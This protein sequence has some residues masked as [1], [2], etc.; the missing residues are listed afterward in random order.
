MSFEEKNVIKKCSSVCIIVLHEN[1]V[2][3]IVSIDCLT[4]RITSNA[5]KSFLAT[6]VR[7]VNMYE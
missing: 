2:V 4:I 6:L 5:S 7:Y 1:Q 3:Q